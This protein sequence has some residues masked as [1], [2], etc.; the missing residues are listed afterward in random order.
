MSNLPKEIIHYDILTRLPVKSLLRFK[1]VCKCWYTLINSS[2][3]LNINRKYTIESHNYYYYYC[4]DLL[5]VGS[6][7]DQSFTYL[8]AP[9]FSCGISNSFD[10]DT[11]DFESNRI[12]DVSCNG[13]M[14]LRWDIYGYVL[15]NPLTRECRKTITTHSFCNY[16]Y[17]I[18]RLA[19]GFG[20][21]SVSDDY[22]IIEILEFRGHK[23]IPLGG[24]ANIYST[25]TDSWKEGDKI[26]TF[27]T[28]IRVCEGVV[29]NKLHF[30]C[31]KTT[32]AD[33]YLTILSIDLHTGKVKCMALSEKLAEI[34]DRKEC[35]LM[36]SNGRL[37]F[38][39][40][41]LKSLQASIWVMKEYGVT[42]SWTKLYELEGDIVLSKIITYNIS[43]D[44]GEV[45]LVRCVDEQN[46]EFVWYNLEDKSFR[47][48]DVPGTRKYSAYRL[49]CIEASLAPILGDSDRS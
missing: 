4:R 10:D 9:Q 8:Y 33:K 38:R 27:V 23:N 26:S 17:P 45:L 20:Y 43:K 41:N 7:S 3:F 34:D 24:V 32:V 11:I 35:L 46:D 12:I 19:S 47:K 22:K 1:S 6:T 15:C 31:S 25:R 39:T 2:T 16:N 42:E 49:V 48:V 37:Y 13:V 5:I 36:A 21:D 40:S 30:I 18:I 28:N 44:G 14:C 29:H